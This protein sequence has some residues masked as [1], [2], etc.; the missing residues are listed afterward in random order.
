[1]QETETATGCVHHWVL[2]TPEEEVVRGR[3][4]RCGC[5]RDYP[6]SLEQYQAQKP[7]E[8]AAAINASVRLLPDLT[9][10]P[11]LSAFGGAW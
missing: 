9:Q 4:K 8:E 11:P 3:C 6:A 10:D 1:M 7:L 5:M 2:G